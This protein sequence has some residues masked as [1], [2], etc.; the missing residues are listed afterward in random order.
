MTWRRRVRHDECLF[1]CQML[2]S[3]NVPG[4]YSGFAKSSLGCVEMTQLDRQS[5]GAV[6]GSGSVNSALVATDVWLLEQQ[7]GWQA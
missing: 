7:S 4:A 2:E 5:I 3:K 6:F 1:F